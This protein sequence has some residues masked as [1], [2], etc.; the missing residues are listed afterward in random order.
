MK[1][2]ILGLS[3]MKAGIAALI[4]IG[5]LGGQVAEAV[6][7]AVPTATPNPALVNELIQLDGTGSYDTDPTLS[8]D[9]WEWDTDND[10]FFDDSSGP[11]S[12]LSFPSVG[13]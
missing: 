9:S 13:D 1:S 3:P 8:I 12:F 2:K 11:F 10:G 6:P 5:L 4:A 7:I